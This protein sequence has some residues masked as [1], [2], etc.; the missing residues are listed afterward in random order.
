MTASTSAAPAC[1][2]RRRRSSCSRRHAGRRTRRGSAAARR[3]LL[4]GRGQPR[5]R[6]LAVEQ[7]R[8][9]RRVHPA[10]GGGRRAS[11]RRWRYAPRPGRPARSSRFACRTSRRRRTA[12]PPSGTQLLEWL[13]MPHH[14][15]SPLA[16][17]TLFDRCAGRAPLYDHALRGPA[18]P[19]AQH[20]RPL[21]PHPICHRHS[22][23]HA[24]RRDAQRGGV[25]SPTRSACEHRRAQTHR[26]WSGG[27]AASPSG[28]RRRRRRAAQPAAGGRDGVGAG[29]SGRRRRPRRSQGRPPPPRAPPPR[30]PAPPAA[31]RVRI[32]RTAHRRVAADR[33]PRC[34]RRR[35]PPRPSA[36]AAAPLV[37]AVLRAGAVAAPPF[38]AHD[39]RRHFWRSAAATS[40][41]PASS[42]CVAPPQRAQLCCALDHLSGE[43]GGEWSAG[44]ERQ[45]PTRRAWQALRRRRS[46][47][48]TRTWCSRSS[49]SSRRC[50]RATIGS[51]RT[52]RRTAFTS[53]CCARAPHCFRIRPHCR[54]SADAVT[55]AHARVRDGREPRARRPPRLRR[56]RRD[57]A[58]RARPP[59]LRRRRRGP[60]RRGVARP[61]GTGIRE[62]RGLHPPRA[63]RRRRRRR[64]GGLV[65]AGRRSVAKGGARMRDSQRYTT[66]YRCEIAA[67]LPAAAC[68][69]WPRGG[70]E[71]PCVSSPLPKAT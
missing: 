61:D 7:L 48:G 67:Q 30:W 46:S 4:E 51:S 52:R 20:R 64:L 60:A 43:L 41:S 21:A 33:L 45:G 3:G 10:G 11:T 17:A 53:R 22:P 35:R 9:V 32:G 69:K 34:R 6:R 62:P 2:R 55:L 59:L 37:A 19:R 71:T 12:A 58:A 8:G 18:P 57:R 42:T 24:P 13:L 16:T 56:P 23:R 25:R 47:R 28:R 26:L 50:A 1:A 31:R 15:E 40:P 68:E 29:A 44:G 39:G 5:P 65:A 38:G 27:G 70:W 49:A 66:K 14:A 63:R 36:A 54:A